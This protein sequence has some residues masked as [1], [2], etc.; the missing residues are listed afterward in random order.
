MI[1]TYFLILKNAWPFDVILRLFLGH[2]GFGLR[3][4]RDLLALPFTIELNLNY[5]HCLVFKS[6]QW[7]ANFNIFKDLKEEGRVKGSEK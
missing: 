3:G 2:T 7:P 5:N 4:S 6:V 1:K